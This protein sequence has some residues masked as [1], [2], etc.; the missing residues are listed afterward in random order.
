ME[1][2]LPGVEGRQGDTLGGAELG[3]SQA[4]VS[5][6]GE[7]FGPELSGSATAARRG[8]SFGRSNGDVGHERPPGDRA[9]PARYSS[10]Q[11]RDRPGAYAVARNE[12]RIDPNGRWLI[13]V[14]SQ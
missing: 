8:K 13:P 6:T 9:T 12:M 14:D 11:G 10:C 1:A 5:K 3:R 7:P 2:A 4:R